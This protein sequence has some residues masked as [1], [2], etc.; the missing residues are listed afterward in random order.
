M[1]RH[2]VKTEADPRRKRRAG[3]GVIGTLVVVVLIGVVAVV[4]LAKQFGGASTPKD[5]PGPGSGSAVVVV[6]PGDTATAIAKTLAAAD[7]VRTSAAFVAAAGNDSRSRGIVPGT[8][9]MKK[10]MSADGALALMLD[11]S[12][13]Q[14][15]VTIPEGTRL[16]ATLEL[17]AANTRLSLPSLRAAAADVGSLGLPAYAQNPR[18]AEGFL[19]PAQYDVAPGDDSAAF[20][21][22]MVK[23]YETTTAGIG[24]VRRA[25]AVGRD[26]YDVLIVASIV[27]DEVGPADYAKAARVIYNRLERGQRLQLDSTVN[28]A[29]NRK[30]AGVTI[31]DTQVASPYNTYLIAGLP[32]TPINSPGQAAIEAALAPVKGPWLYWVTTNLTTGETKFATT[33]QEFTRYKAEFDASQR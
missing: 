11:P 12:A 6:K 9:A 17:I 28:Y 19:F 8:Y 23:R 31:A 2:A 5:Y 14:D 3:T 33:Y 7:V 27:Q 29:L 1:S 25:A 4:V 15:V 16:S 24:L 10:Q 13:R 18:T 22:S 20:L 32:P 21:R 30:T 26:P